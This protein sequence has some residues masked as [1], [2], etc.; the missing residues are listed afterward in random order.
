LNEFPTPPVRRNAVESPTIP[1]PIDIT[2]S[3][4]NR[5][6]LN[7]T[8]ST[9]EI[10]QKI[11]FELRFQRPPPPVP[12]IQYGFNFA[13]GSPIEWTAAPRTTHSYSAAGTYEPS[14]EV[15]VGER[16]LELPR[17]VG[18]TVQVVPQ[19]SPT[20]TSTATPAPI[21]PSPSPY[22]PSPTALPTATPISPS[23]E[24]HLSVDKNP[25]SAGDSVTFSIVTN[26]PAG[27]HSYAVD[28]GDG[29]KPIRITSNS[30]PHIFKAAG[31]YTASVTLLNDGSH[32]RADLA[33]LVD[34]RRSSRVWVYILVALAVVTLVYLIFQRS[35]LKIPMAAQPTFHPHS[36]WDAPQTSPK[37]LTI[38]YGLYFHPNISA[39]QDR[40][41]NDEPGSI[42]RKKKQ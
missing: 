28:F 35:K 26:L 8:P 16:L 25:I 34:A 38:N 5:V 20:P 1:P 15:R 7:V 17:I 4:A 33:I 30:V 19:P 24:V 37:N 22:T 36:D 12:N 23:H 32:A 29:S 21:T 9:V 41:E 6:I 14:V 42:L 10:D 18:P 2:A 27:N 3:L 11:R 13:D 31:N 40:L 39:G